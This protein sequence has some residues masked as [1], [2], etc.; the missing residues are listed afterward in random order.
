MLGEWVTKVVSSHLIQ[1]KNPKPKT[2]HSFAN[3]QKLLTSLPSRTSFGITLVC[4]ESCSPPCCCCCWHERNSSRRGQKR[5]TKT[6][7]GWRTEGRKRLVLRTNK[8]KKALLQT[9]ICSF[10][11]WACSKPQLLARY[12]YEG[13]LFIRRRFKFMRLAASVLLWLGDS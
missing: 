7:D 1:K 6:N 13:E 9:T 10:F 8:L 3:F 2:H 4:V 12:F 5:T 11:W